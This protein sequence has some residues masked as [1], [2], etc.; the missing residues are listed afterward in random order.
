MPSC[1]RIVLDAV[2]GIQRERVYTI[3]ASPEGTEMTAGNNSSKV[4][5]FKEENVCKKVK[6]S[7]IIPFLNN[8]S[9]IRRCIKSVQQQS[10]IDLEIICVDNGSTD[11]GLR[12][13]QEISEDD[14]RVKLFFESEAGAGPSRNKGLIESNGIYVIFIDADDR[15]ASNESLSKLLLVA[16]KS[17]SPLVKGNYLIVDKKGSR[18]PK[19][20]G[21]SFIINE[22]KALYWY[23]TYKLSIFW[24]LYTYLIRRDFLIKNGIVSPSLIRAQDSVFIARMFRKIDTPIPC[25]PDIVYL[26]YQGS[27]KWNFEDWEYERVLSV[28]QAY[29]T[30]FIFFRDENKY[31]QWIWYQATI[32][33]KIRK[34]ITNFGLDKYS[35]DRLY[36]LCKELLGSL[37]NHEEMLSKNP[38]Q[39]GLPR[40]YSFLYRILV[41]FE[42][43][44]NPKI[45]IV[46]IVRDTAKYLHK[47]VES[48]LEQEFVNW[49][50]LLINGSL[51]E[52]AHEVCNTLS[53]NDNRINVLHVGKRNWRI[54]AAKGVELAGGNYI[55]FINSGDYLLNTCIYSDVIKVY[56]KINTDIVAFR[57][58]VENDMD[59][60]LSLASAYDENIRNSLSYSKGNVLDAAQY[61]YLK[62]FGNTPP[63][64]WN[65]IYRIE[66]VKNHLSLGK[67]WKRYRISFFKILLRNPTFFC[68]D[69]ILDC[70]S[71]RKLNYDEKLGNLIY[72]IVIRVLG[73]KKT[74]CE[75]L[76]DRF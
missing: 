59:D 64:L 31:E 34:L 61:G 23:E 27:G 10:I 62:L 70:H 72:K 12:I 29:K 40:M 19:I 53:Q 60:S 38:F 46:V 32:L 75:L 13:I 63:C 54:L 25:I 52:L 30:L 43:V 66:V 16:E 24:G 35:D 56:K 51:A 36:S 76:S 58:R 3:I 39:K 6:I 22:E 69:G 49:E 68:C 50:I 33:P 47:T 9:T 45:T 17:K 67:Q 44:E 57:E 14:E 74:L 55:H 18:E 20:D 28:F 41:N 73:I 5:L 1:I 48:I 42:P 26:Y 37:H 71:L 21:K 8:A 15:L 4:V 7:V 65:K 2:P 11:E